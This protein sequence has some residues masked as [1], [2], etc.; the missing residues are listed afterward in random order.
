MD[1]KKKIKCNGLKMC[2]DEIY[3]IEIVFV[4]LIKD[5]V[6]YLKNLF[7]EKDVKGIDIILFV[8]GFFECLF[9]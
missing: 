3:L 7:V 6:K 2:I 1:L 5:I 9:L 4:G 8:G